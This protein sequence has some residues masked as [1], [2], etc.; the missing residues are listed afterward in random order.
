PGAAASKRVNWSK[1]LSDKEAKEF[2]VENIFLDKNN[3]SDT[4]WYL[5]TS[6]Q[7]FEWPS[8]TP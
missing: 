8:K 4:S 1:Q 2:T 3:P 7:K 5:I 6:G